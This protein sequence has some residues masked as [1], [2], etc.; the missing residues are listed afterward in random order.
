MSKRKHEYGKKIAVVGAGPSG[1][2]CAY[3]LA[4]DGY[5][6]TVF[7]KEN[8][9]GGMLTLGIPS[10]RLEKNVI[11]AEIDILKEL[12]VEFKTGVEVGR[13]ISLN[14]LRDQGFKAVYI[15]IGACMGR[16]LGIEGENVENVITGIDFMRDVNLGK[17]LKLEGNVIVIG[18]GNVAIDVARTAT[19]IGNTQIK[20]FGKS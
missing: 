11:N 20:L 18:G 3:Y 15:A 4:I 6:V 17:E 2:S 7:E 19:R 8:V 16:N 5:K 9:L 10:F 14:E 1:L 13:D 12:G